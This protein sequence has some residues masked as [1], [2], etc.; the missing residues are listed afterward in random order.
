M[1]A[2]SSADPL[3]ASGFFTMVI[4]VGPT[5]ENGALVWNLQQGN[6][7]ALPALGGSLALCELAADAPAARADPL[8]MSNCVL[9]GARRG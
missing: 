2:G 7:P 3:Y 1:I 6:A 5:V 8:S 4:G 9:F